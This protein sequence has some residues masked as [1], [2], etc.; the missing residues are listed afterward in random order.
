[1]TLANYYP[2][3]LERNQRIMEWLILCLG[4]LLALVA[5]SY[6]VEALRPQPTAPQSL[7]W[8]PDIPLKYIEVEGIKLRYIV[9]GEGSTLVLLHTL[10]TQL[11]LFQKVIGELAQDFQVYAFDYPG[12]GYSDIP[13]VEYSPE[14]FAKSVRGFLEQLNLTNVTL[15]GESIGGTLG[16]LLAAEHNPRVA[17]AIAINSYDYDRGRGITRGSWLSNIVFS[18]S[19][20]PVI[21]GT[22]WRLRWYGIFAQIMKGS[23]HNDA[24]L[25]PAL[26]R[27]MHEVG[28]RRYHYRA[29][30]SLIAHF[31]DWEELR[32]QYKNI[33]IPVLLVYGEFDWSYVSERKSNQEVIPNARLETISE[34]GHL[35][36]LDTPEA[37]IKVAR[38]FVSHH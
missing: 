16:L 2:V 26:L 14:L 13:Q 35:L 38:E 23:V 1:M 31:P 25:I 18:L 24:S 20:V 9:T 22:I 28:N 12:H 32:S 3:F 8:A 27:E 36:S 4:S 33:E 37:T 11:D 17:K 34:A 10:R 7:D 5:I 21:G 6:G 30:M 15:V 19:N 29:F